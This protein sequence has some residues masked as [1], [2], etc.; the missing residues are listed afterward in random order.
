MVTSLSRTAFIAAVAALSPAPGFAQTLPADCSAATVPAQPVA[1]SIGGARF[2]PKGVKLRD[3]GG[4]TYG[5]QAYD[6]FRLSLRSE[7]ELSPPLEAEVTVLVRKGQRLDGKVFRKLP[8]KDTAKQ[9]S[10]TSGLPEVQGW[11]LKNRPGRTDL[12]HVS[13]IGSLRL[14]FAQRQGNS[15]S[16][17][18]YLCVAKGQTTIFDSTPSKEDSFAIGTFQALIE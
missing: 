10:P 12:S 7:D 5:E 14:E 11:S 17:K 9:P 15:I 8:V 6:T 18:I 4:M 13:Y 2:T 3:A 1:V 16:G